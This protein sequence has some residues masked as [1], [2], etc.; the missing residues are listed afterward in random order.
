[1]LPRVRTDEL[2]GVFG[3]IDHTREL[4][5]RHLADAAASAAATELSKRTPTAIAA[6]RAAIEAARLEDFYCFHMFVF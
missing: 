3:M 5:W 2:A 6:R 1:M 4:D